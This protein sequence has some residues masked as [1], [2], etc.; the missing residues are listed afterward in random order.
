VGSLS[1]RQVSSGD[2]SV[3]LIARG[4]VDDDTVEAFERTLDRIAETAFERLV[5]DL[6][7]CELASAGLGA[8]IRLQRRLQSR[9]EAALLVATDVDL[10]WTLRVVGLTYW[11]RV[12]ETL[13]A[14]L[15]EPLGPLVEV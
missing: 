4:V 2:G 11:F 7:A 1:V 9:V 3:A 13:E 10:I 12:C 8:L 14:A 6:T 15:L 5:I